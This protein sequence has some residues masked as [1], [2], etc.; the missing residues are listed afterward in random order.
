MSQQAPSIFRLIGLVAVVFFILV[1]LTIAFVD[2]PAPSPVFRSVV[3]VHDSLIPART[4]G[5][6]AEAGPPVLESEIQVRHDGINMSSQGIRWKG[7]WFSVHEIEGQPDVP[8]QA[9]TVR[10]GEPQMFAFDVGD[11]TLLTWLL[12]G[13]TIAVAS[14][15]AQPDLLELALMV[16]PTGRYVPPITPPRGRPSQEGQPG[17][18]PGPAPR[19]R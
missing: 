3:S 18:G 11:L 8:P 4:V 12:D 10:A 1:V 17:A 6:S 13:H 14:S 5:A 15:A 2:G 16:E 7:V 19:L 9:R